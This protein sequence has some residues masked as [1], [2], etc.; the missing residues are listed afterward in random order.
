MIVAV[1]V[2]QDPMKLCFPTKESYQHI[3][4]VALEPGGASI[5]T[6][7][8]IHWGSTGRH[9]SDVSIYFCPALQ[10]QENIHATD[11]TVYPVISDLVGKLCGY[12]VSPRI[13]MSFSF[14]DPKFE[15]PYISATGVLPF[16]SLELRVALMSAQLINYSSLGGT[17]YGG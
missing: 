9:G 7:R 8:A 3:R 10:R 17:D 14:A 12:Q 1:Q 5:H 11:A 2:E 16:P 13:S 4:A 6:H 15:P